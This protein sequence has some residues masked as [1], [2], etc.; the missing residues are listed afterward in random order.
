[1]P[2]NKQT[3]RKSA[4]IINTS[5]SDQRQSPQPQ[6]R[7]QPPRKQVNPKKGVA[8]YR[9]D[10][11]S[12]EI[13]KY[14]ESRDLLLPRAPVLR[15]VREIM[16]E[17]SE[18]HGNLRIQRFALEAIRHA[19]EAFL[20]NMFEDVNMLAVH[21]RRVTIMPKDIQLIKRLH[22]TMNDFKKR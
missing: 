21:A 6:Q 14:Q 20:V 13:A 17:Q 18:I 2:R 9:K 10:R 5:D 3:A 4:R 22:M 1:M 8:A 12:Q 19:A 11:V 16:K 7:Q 15:L